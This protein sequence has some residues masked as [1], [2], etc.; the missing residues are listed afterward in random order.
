M[1]SARCCNSSWPWWR[2]V[3]QRS[4]SSRARLAARRA[5]VAAPRRRRNQLT[6]LVVSCHAQTA[7][8]AAE[9]ARPIVWVV[10][11]VRAD[12]VR[13]ANARSNG[14]FGAWATG[15]R[16][17]HPAW[18]RRQSSTGFI[19]SIVADRRAEVHYCLV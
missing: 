6:P 7:R 9:M 2:Q 13:P 4:L 17:G 11:A 1:R 15:N 18:A 12:R 10:P 3:A 5:S 16:C 8:P 14:G 19:R